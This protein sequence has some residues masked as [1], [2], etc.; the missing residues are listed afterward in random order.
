MGIRIAL[1]T[2]MLGLSLSFQAA[3]GGRAETFYTLIIITYALTIPS[4]LLLRALTSPVA[5]TIFFWSQVG[6]D[7]QIGRAH[8]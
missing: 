7:F 1:V 6:I 2:L 8:V 3:K 4:A 5:L